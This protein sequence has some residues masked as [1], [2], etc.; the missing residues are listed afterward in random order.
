M[1]DDEATRIREVVE[2]LTRRHPDVPA[3]TV[4]R[5]VHRSHARFADT[6]VRD[7]IPLLVERNARNELSEP[8]LR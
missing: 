4:E 6:P 8:P 2:R 7:F 1:I 5:V 3:E